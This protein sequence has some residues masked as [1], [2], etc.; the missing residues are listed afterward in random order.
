MSVLVTSA[1]ILYAFSLA[2]WIFAASKSKTP[3]E[4][5]IASKK[6]DGAR[7]ATTIFASKIGAGL[8]LT[9]S[10]LVFS[11]GIWAMS[12]FVGFIAGYTL[13]Y[14]FARKL[15]KATRDNDIVSMAGVYRAQFGSSVGR[16]IG[17]VG[18]LSMFGWV[19][20]N[21]IGGGE[22]I[23]RTSGIGFDLSVV[24]VG[25]TVAT[26]VFFGGFSA[27]VK[28]DAVQSIAMFV[29]FF[30]I[31]IALVQTPPSFLLFSTDTEVPWGEI[32]VFLL[33][34]L[35][36]P[37][38]SAELWERVIA[39]DSERALKRSLFLSS[40]AY[41][42][43]GVV[44]GVICTSI[45]QIGEFENPN[46]ALIE[47]L[48]S[49]LPSWTGVFLVFAFASAILSSADTFVYSMASLINQSVI[50]GVRST[51]LDRVRTLRVVMIFVVAA[52]V[53]TAILIRNIID[54]TL[55]FVAIT[56]VLSVCGMLLWFWPK[57]HQQS[58]MVGA[59]GALLLVIV[60]WIGAG[61]SPLLVVVG[62]VG[63]LVLSLAT[64]AG[65][66]FVAK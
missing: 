47:G 33:T 42:A 37:L 11:Y 36:F 35:L 53:F 45:S 56:L 40:M 31:A 26:Y 54:V 29:I 17:G 25:L 10:V 7:G 38:G 55:L 34:G 15:H 1:L 58:I 62:L 22:L 61:V 20:T 27:V 24:I 57:I 50:H 52:G 39:V 66:F 59:I 3:Y 49:V 9:Y 48:L 43:F 13:F 6:L 8:I 46:V 28:T 2:I 19:I 5:V 30:V 12:L 4:F 18:A 44:L 21:L 60:T 41:I 64:A 14:F 16:V 23:A 51:M 32:A 65:T 63:A